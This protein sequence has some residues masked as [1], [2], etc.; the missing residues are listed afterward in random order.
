MDNIYIYEGDFISLLNVINYLLKNQIKPNNIKDMSYNATLFENNIYLSLESDDKFIESVINDLGL[1][2]LQIMYNVFLS[3]E[4]N[5]ELIIYYFFRN[6]LKYKDNIIYHRNLKCVSE[7]LRINNYV[8]HEAH[9]M[10]GFLRFKEY[11][12]NIL[13][14]EMEPTNDIILFLSCHFAKRLKNEY[15]IIKDKKRKIISM[16]DKKKFAILK[17]EDVKL[18]INNKSEEE[19]NYEELWKTFYKTIGIKDRKNDRCRRNFMPKKY[20]KYLIEVEDEI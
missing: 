20:W 13:Y 5:K 4:E 15:W 10:K 14:A 9:K 1:I 8:R 16:Y 6:A 2:T 17:E 11:E 18:S 3:I 7:S 19:E 12:N